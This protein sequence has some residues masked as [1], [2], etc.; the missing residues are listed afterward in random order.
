MNIQSKKKSHMLL[1]IGLTMVLWLSL[2]L[3]VMATEAGGSRI[4]LANKLHIEVEVGY[5]GQYVRGKSTPVQFTVTNDYSRD[6]KGELVLNV[7]NE[8][9]ISV[10]HILPLE[11]T[12]GSTVEAYMTVEGGLTEKGTSIQFYEGGVD[13]GQ[14][15]DIAGTTHAIGQGVSA[16]TAI[17]IVA[18]DP[19]TLNFVAFLNNQGFS[20]SPIVLDSDFYAM[21]MH[22]LDMFSILVLNDI[23]TSEWP[24][25]KVKAIKD[26]VA[27]GG[28][29]LFGGGAGY[30]QTATAFSD[31][32]PV[33]GN[34]TRLW[35]QSSMLAEYVGSAE[36]LQP[37]PITEG[38]L[39]KGQAILQ[40]GGTPIT[41]VA[42]FGHGSIYYTA[43]DLGLK[44]FSI[45]DGRTA[46]IQSLLSERLMLAGT[47]DTSNY[48]WALENSSNHFPRLQPPQVSALLIIFFVYILI[49]APILYIVLKRL[50]RREWLW[51]MIPLLA[52]LSTIIIVFV[53]S[54]DK[55]SFYVN[56]IRV[57][58][59]DQEATREIGVNN[60]FIP[61]NKDIV[62]ELPEQNYVTVLNGNQNTGQDVSNN[63]QQRIYH[64]TPSKEV[65]FTNNKYWTM[66]SVMLGEQIYNSEQYGSITT[67]IELVNNETVLTVHNETGVNLKHVSLAA[68]SS[69]HY[70]DDLPAGE[71]L[72]YKLPQ[73]FSL[74]AIANM[75]M[76]HNNYRYDFQQGTGQEW[77]GVVRETYLL[78][79]MA[80]FPYSAMI[81]AFSYNDE[82]NYVVN[83]K[84]VKSDELKMWVVNMEQEFSEGLW[85]QQLFAPESAVVE[86]GDYSNFNDNKQYFS[87]VEGTVEMKYALPSDTKEGLQAEIIP[88]P[89]QSNGQLTMQIYNVQSGEWESA[90]DGKF[91]L[92]PYVDE[93]NIVKIKIDSGNNYYEGSLPMLLLDREVQS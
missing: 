56:G 39:V 90:P 64:H 34:E 71:K 87:L 14:A 76:Y 9:G 55:S 18:N 59:I 40:D 61:N 7:Q 78:D 46:Y 32:T 23:A 50:D 68:F 33:Q 72:E 22:D 74:D 66:K 37:L 85:N 3:P 53:G 54:K 81:I 89:S 28:T 75:S 13:R 25:Q 35:E 52:V 60:I 16:T 47:L 79:N 8:R 77:E 63:K 1:I 86:R 4:A 57:A 19:D 84:N 67:S 2:S 26:W 92:Q 65:M 27:N 41:A 20:I 83:D 88:Q 30:A 58:M 49:V 11:I 42:K 44:P 69:L 6:L 24:E 38:K 70:I 36:P 51:W 73:S 62:F 82:P 15:L 91:E 17:G 10:A 43:F 80:F 21:S 31:L 5:N 12:Q 29:L 93:W 45:W 48:S